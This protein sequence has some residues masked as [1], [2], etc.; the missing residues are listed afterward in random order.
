MANEI[1]R[2]ALENLAGDIHKFEAADQYSLPKNSSI[3]KKMEAKVA[4][5]SDDPSRTGGFESTI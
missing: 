5:M 4:E 3:S 1:N 2:E